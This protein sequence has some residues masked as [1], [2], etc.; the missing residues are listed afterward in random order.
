MGLQKQNAYFPEKSTPVIYGANNHK[1]KYVGG[2]FRK[3]TIRTLGGQL[4]NVNSVVQYSA[5][6]AVDQSVLVSGTHLGPATNFFFSFRFS[7][8]SC[9]FVI[10]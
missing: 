2:I 10:L 9:E 6:T 5:P 1:Y 7:S 4:G 3:I 8:D